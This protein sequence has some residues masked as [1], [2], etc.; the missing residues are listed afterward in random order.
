VFVQHQVNNWKS[1]LHWT[2]VTH[3]VFTARAMLVWSWE[4]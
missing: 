2:V 4:S 3:T 1:I